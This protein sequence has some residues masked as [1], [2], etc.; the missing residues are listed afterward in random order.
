[1]VGIGKLSTA[2]AS[3]CLIILTA[4]K[5][6]FICNWAQ[7]YYVGRQDG[8]RYSLKD[9]NTVV[10]LL[11]G[12]GPTL[13]KYWQNLFAISPGSLIVTPHSCITLV[14]DTSLHCIALYNGNVL[15]CD[16]RMLSA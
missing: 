9:L 12:F 13:A 5:S 14:V 6:S 10:I 15:C 2:G 11:A 1:M 3:L 16:L 4:S 8:I 7:N